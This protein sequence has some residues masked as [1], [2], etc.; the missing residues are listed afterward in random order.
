MLLPDPAELSQLVQVAG[1]LRRK[2]D[3][4]SPEEVAQDLQDL[5]RLLHLVR[6]KYGDVDS[7]IKALD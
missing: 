2:L 7:F 1:E 6:R 4:L 3:N 5:H